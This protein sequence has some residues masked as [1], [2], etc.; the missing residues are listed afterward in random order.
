MDYPPRTRIIAAVIVGI[1]FLLI[2]FGTFELIRA[3]VT[4]DPARDT[5]RELGPTEPK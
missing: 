3:L 5:A 2:A 1:V 4:Y